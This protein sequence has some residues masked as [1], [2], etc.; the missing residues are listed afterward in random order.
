MLSG[1]ALSAQSPKAGTYIKMDGVTQDG[2]AVYQKSAGGNYLYFWAGR[3]WC[4][5]TNYTDFAAGLTSMSNGNTQCPEAEGDSWEYWTGEASIPGGI[6][7]GCPSPPHPPGLAPLP[8][9]PSPPP[10]SP[11][12][13]P[14]TEHSDSTGTLIGAAVGGGV[15]LIL[16]VVLALYCLPLSQAKPKAKVEP[17]YSTK[18]EPFAGEPKGE[19]RASASRP[20]VQHDSPDESMAELGSEAGLHSHEGLVHDAEAAAWTPSMKI[21]PQH[22]EHA[23]FGGA[24]ARQ[25]GRPRG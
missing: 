4:V 8:A 16:F 3:D 13:A 24:A 6:A 22:V 11:P 5:G 2:R 20:L 12:N 21:V 17:D 9:S 25:R 7:V 19:L 1:G 10:P 14:P 15:A 18:V 23:R